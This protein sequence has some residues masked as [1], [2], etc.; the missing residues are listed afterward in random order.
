VIGQCPLGVKLDKTQ[1]EHNAPLSGASRSNR[2]WSGQIRK[3]TYHPL[4]S[5]E[6]LCALATSPALFVVPSSSPY[7]TL[8][9][10]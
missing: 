4:E 2:C 7:H 1:S 6:P 5:F 9:D 10:F 8:G 3:A